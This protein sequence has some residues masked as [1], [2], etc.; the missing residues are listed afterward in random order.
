MTKYIDLT[1]QRFGRWLVLKFDKI[2]NGIAYWVCRCDCG[3]EKIVNGSSLRRGRSHS[4]GCISNEINK[5][6][7]TKHGHC[8]G[9]ISKIYRIWCSMI[10]RCYN[11]NN[12]QYKNY[13]QRSIEVCEHWLKFEN[14]LID[15][16][17]RPNKMSLDRIDNNGNYCPENCRWAT[18]KQQARNRRNTCLFTVNNETKCLK[19]WCKHFGLNYK[20]VYSRLNR[21]WSLEEALGLIKRKGKK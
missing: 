14:F 3:N 2:A 18:F 16:G 8:T 17:E 9:K 10:E 21:R 11:K 20:C 7:M 15:M 19:D 12:K 6:R 4:C 13:G 1:G 5:K